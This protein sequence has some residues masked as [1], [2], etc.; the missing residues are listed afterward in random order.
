MPDETFFHELQRWAAADR[1]GAAV[2][3]RVRGR[4]L[5]DQ[6]AGSARWA[7]LLVDLAEQGTTVS[8]LLPGGRLDGRLV[9]AATDFCVVERA[10][11]RSVLV[12]SS[13]IRTLTHDGA[14][15][16]ASG[17]RR[18]LL[19]LTL[20]AALD[21]LAAEQSPVTLHLGADRLSGLLVGLG[22]DVLT[23]RA[24]APPRR[25]TYAPLTAVE[26]VEVR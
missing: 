20:A 22:E 16:R 14:T 4:A 13:V 3:E 8:L 24:E 25:F 19:E 26:A 18:P 12:R 21:G 11:H 2:G 7:G 17:D 9:G 10:G 15:R 1:A 5:A 6:E 23:L